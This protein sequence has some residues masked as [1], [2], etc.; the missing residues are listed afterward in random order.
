MDDEGAALRRAVARRG[1]R[2]AAGDG[3]RGRCARRERHA[4]PAD[5]GDGESR[6]AWTQVGSQGELDEALENGEFYGALIV[7]EVHMIGAGRCAGALHRG[8]AR[9]RPRRRRRPRTSARATARSRRCRSSRGFARRCGTWR[10][11]DALQRGAVAKVVVDMRRARGRARSAGVMF[12][13]RASTWRNEGIGSTH[14]AAVNPMAGNEL[15]SCRCLARRG[16]EVL[17][18][19]YG[20]RARRAVRVRDAGLGAGRHSTSS[21]WRVRAHDVRLA[22]SRRCRRSGRTGD[23]R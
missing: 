6:I 4:R 3:E 23:I 9:L 10:L 21:R 13:Q 19:A 8:H 16:V 5:A 20:G 1:R 18:A 22:A 17:Q 11:M 12:Q 14:A 15:P 7:P 2:G